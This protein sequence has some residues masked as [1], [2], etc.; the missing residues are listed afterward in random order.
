[1]SHT[2][3]PKLPKDRLFLSK[4][5]WLE[6]LQR[7]LGH[8]AVA[9]R[10]LSRARRPWRASP[11]LQEWPSPATSSKPRPQPGR[12][13]TG[14]PVR[15]A[16]QGPDQPHFCAQSPQGLCPCWHVDPTLPWT[17]EAHFTPGPARRRTLSCASGTLSRC[18]VLGIERRAKRT[19]SLLR[20]DKRLPQGFTLAP[21]TLG[22]DD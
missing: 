13:P 21:L 14:Y 2:F 12:L 20:E 3:P 19:L 16:H 5:S 17:Q 8:T 1:M 10:C 9:I 15:P 6:V 7:S 22:S 4:L 11:D 18:H